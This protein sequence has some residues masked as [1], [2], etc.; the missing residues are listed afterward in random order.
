M[1]RELDPPN[2][3]GESR[4]ARQTTWAG[5]ENRLFHGFYSNQRGG[6]R[7]HRMAHKALLKDPQVRR[8]Y[9]NVSRG[10]EPTA[11]VYLRRL[12]LFCKRW[13]STPAGLLGKR[14]REIHNLLVDTVTELERRGYAGSYGQAI[15]KA[16]KSWLSSNNITLGEI[17]IN[18]TDPDDTRLCEKRGHLS[19]ANSERLSNTH[20]RGPE[21][22]WPSVHSAALGRGP[23]PIMTELTAWKYTTYRKF[24]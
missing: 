14:P 19:Q 24:T 15:V 13:H 21:P 18:F 17:R 1:K 5:P 23:W 9:D 4:R 11:Q 12:G 16:V 2:K 10:S 22:Q 7:P 8:W 3:S 6:S 20:A